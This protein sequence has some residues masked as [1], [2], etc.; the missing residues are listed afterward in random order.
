VQLD[1]SFEPSGHL[2]ATAAASATTPLSRCEIE[3][4]CKIAEGKGLGAW[5]ERHVNKGIEKV[6]ACY[7]VVSPTR[8]PTW[9]IWGGQDRSSIK[10]MDVV[11]R[12]ARRN[13]VRV[14]AVGEAVGS[15]L[16]ERRRSRRGQIQLDIERGAQGT[17]EQGGSR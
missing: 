2:R 8:K 14:G 5:I 10:E 12:Q 7:E 15:A 6:A 1:K 16:L 9:G 13:I 3:A 17:T 4:N 11:A